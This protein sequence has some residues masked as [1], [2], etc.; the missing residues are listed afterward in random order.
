MG[1]NDKGK[2]R[3][4]EEME[5]EQQESEKKK[6]EERKEKEEIRRKEK[7]ILE[8]IPISAMLL[9]VFNTMISCYNARPKIWTEMEP[10]T[11]IENTEEKGI[12]EDGD[13]WTM[14]EYPHEVYLKS[15]DKIFD[16]AVNAFI[17]NV[18]VINRS[19][20]EILFNNLYLDVKQ[21]SNNIPI[22]SV[23][24][25][26]I[27][28][29]LTINIENLS[30][31]EVEFLEL[32]ISD[33]RNIID[34]IMKNMDKIQVRN[35]KANESRN[36]DVFNI[37]EVIEK[38]EDIYDVW[39]SLKDNDG[40]ILYFMFDSYKLAYLGL[41]RYVKDNSPRVDVEYTY[42]MTHDIEVF[43]DRV[44]LCNIQEVVPPNEILQLKL[45]S[46]IERPCALSIGIK[47]KLNFE[48]H[49]SGEK[50]IIIYNPTNDYDYDIYFNDIEYQNPNLVKNK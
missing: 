36:I 34:S 13:K 29:I 40:N 47:Y 4:R 12:E 41:S 17:I 21:F 45:L 42:N 16:V 23:K 24:Y 44:S 6:D 37:S 15:A 3:K 43:N 14:E 9:V 22:V 8:I 35:L 25:G 11:N 38:N 27:N 50:D 5:R 2:K 7:L 28:N 39:L 30:N 49:D 26:V 31:K 46:Y 20:D 32:E 10:V 48:E 33:K 19:E 18:G 1:K